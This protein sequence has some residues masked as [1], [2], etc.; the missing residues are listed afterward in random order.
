[1]GSNNFVLE[2]KVVNGFPKWDPK[3]I[4]LTILTTQDSTA[5]AVR[6]PGFPSMVCVMIG[7][8]YWYV[9]FPFPISLVA[10]VP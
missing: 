9:Y 10:E 4:T 1:M 5:V 8:H 7:T 3:R 2:V 6:A